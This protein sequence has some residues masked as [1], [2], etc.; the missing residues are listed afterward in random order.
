[1]LGTE[2]STSVAS[3]LDSLFST[4]PLETVEEMISVGTPYKNLRQRCLGIEI[5]LAATVLN[6]MLIVFTQHR[7]QA[8]SFEVTG[9]NRESEVPS[10]QFF[11]FRTLQAVSCPQRTQNE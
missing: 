6:C 2:I 11:S 7:S 8:R 5:T 9:L 4:S 10:A 3:S 1:M